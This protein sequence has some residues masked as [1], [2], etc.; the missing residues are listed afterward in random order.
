MYRVRFD[1]LADKQGKAGTLGD[2]GEQQMALHHGEV[3]ADADARA[4]AERQVRVTGK[5][6]L[7]FRCEALGIELFRLRE[8]F[9]SAV[10]GIRSKQDDPALGNEVAIN[11]DIPQCA[12]GE[13]IRWWVEPQRLLEDLQA[14]G[15]TGQVS[16]GRRATLQ[17]AIDFLLNFPITL[18][19][20]AEQ[21]PTPA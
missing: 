16:S 6:F 7:M 9:F 21:V 5:P 20:L 1:A 8:V 18:R 13:G 12:P 19:M 10:Q 11:L 17:D 4:C 14:V 2:S 15:Q 3:H